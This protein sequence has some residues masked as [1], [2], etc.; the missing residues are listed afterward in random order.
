MDDESLK[1]QIRKLADDVF[2]ASREDT[3]DAIFSFVIKILNEQTKDIQLHISDI[4]EVRN[5][6]LMH[7]RDMV[8]PLYVDGQ[9]MTEQQRIAY[10]YLIAMVGFLRK[11]SLIKYLI[12]LDTEPPFLFSIY[13]E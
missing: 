7:C 2:R 10:C 9:P 11:R 4:D 13:E 1:E 5:G 3:R 6:A 8:I 12:D